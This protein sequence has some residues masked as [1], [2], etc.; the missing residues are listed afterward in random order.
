[1]IYVKTHMS[2][3][4]LKVSLSVEL[5]KTSLSEVELLIS[6]V[7]ILHQHLCIEDVHIFK[8]YYQLTHINYMDDQKTR[9]KH[10]S[11]LS[12]N[13]QNSNYP[14]NSTTTPKYTL[15]Q[16]LVFLYYEVISQS[17]VATN[18]RLFLNV[19]C[20]SHQSLLFS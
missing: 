13:N 17:A 19:K 14:T 3:N 5:R 4:L 1:M 20:R 6:Y 7:I 18:I 8:H 11:S 2:I 10:F 15:P 16:R 12:C 9:L